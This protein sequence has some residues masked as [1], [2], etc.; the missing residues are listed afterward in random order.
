MLIDGLAQD[1]I[2]LGI[3]IL[4]LQHGTTIMAPALFH[5]EQTT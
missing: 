3:S 5:L 4:D 1:L 2:S